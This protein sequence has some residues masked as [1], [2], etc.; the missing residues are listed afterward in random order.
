MA[1]V[2]AFQLGLDVGLLHHLEQKA[3]V[4]EGVFEDEIEEELFALGGVLRVVH[5]PHVERGHRRLDLGDVRHAA[6]HRP[7]AAGGEVEDD[8]AA[9]LDL[10]ADSGV[11]IGL[12]GGSALVGA[13]VDVDDRGAGFVGALRFGGDLARGVRDPGALIAVCEDARQRASDDDFAG[14]GHGHL[15]G[16]GLWGAGRPRRNRTASCP[17]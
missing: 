17:A 15:L 2:E 4:A 3:D 9:L 14:L 12:V 1:D 5:R 11:A 8:G 13:S 10:G 16:S 7:A 6:L